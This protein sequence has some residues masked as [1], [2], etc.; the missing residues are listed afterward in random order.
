MERKGRRIGILMF[1]VTMTLKQLPFLF[2]LVF[3]ILVCFFVAA[4][5][6]FFCCCLDVFCLGGFWF[7]LGFF[8]LGF[9]SFLCAGHRPI[10]GFLTLKF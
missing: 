7:A 2:L 6:V 1:R 9:F 5:A 8:L 10:F 3:W 4:V